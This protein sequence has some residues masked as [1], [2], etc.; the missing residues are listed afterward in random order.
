MVER[1]VRNAEV[2]GSTPLI[3]TN[4]TKSGPSLW[5]SD[6]LFQNS[7]GKMRSGT[8]NRNFEKIKVKENYFTTKTL[9]GAS[10]T[11]F[12]LVLPMTQL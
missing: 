2:R 8:T 12:W 4:A 9:Q 11:R 6:L 1:R 10:L 3:S 5:R 7:T